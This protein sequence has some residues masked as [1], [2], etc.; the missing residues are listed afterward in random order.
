ML[1]RGSRYEESTGPMANYNKNQNLKPSEAF[2]GLVQK[3]AKVS[4]LVK[5]LHE[6]VSE[7]EMAQVLQI[8]QQGFNK[9]TKKVERSSKLNGGA[10]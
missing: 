9:H 5:E 2:P 10:K 1:A 4:L 8:S 6:E 7:R 3:L